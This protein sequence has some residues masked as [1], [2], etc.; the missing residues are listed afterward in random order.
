MNTD[1]NFRRKYRFRGQGRSFEE[2]ILQNCEDSHK[3]QLMKRLPQEPSKQSKG[4]LCTWH[5]WNAG[6]KWINLATHTCIVQTEDTV[7]HEEWCKAVEMVANHNII[8]YLYIDFANMK[9]KFE[10]MESFFDFHFCV[11]V[12][13]NLSNLNC[14]LT[15][16]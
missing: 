15:G 4:C 13:A 7:K 8:A 12:C 3:Q 10:Y 14:I 16:K 6:D 5:G 1:S 11:C 9:G 2:G